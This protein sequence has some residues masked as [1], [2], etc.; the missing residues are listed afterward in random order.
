VDQRFNEPEQSNLESDSNLAT[1]WKCVGDDR[2]RSCLFKNLYY[3]KTEFGNSDFMMFV[4]PGQ[5][6]QGVTVF[7]ANKYEGPWMPRV[8]VFNS[9][10]D[11]SDHVATKA[12]V[13]ELGL[14]LMFNPLFHQNIGH[15]LFDGLYPAYM[16]LVKLGL[17]EKNF[18]PIPGIPAGCFD[19]SEPAPSGKLMPG[20]IVEAYLPHAR[21]NKSLRPSK[22]EILQVSESKSTSDENAD[23]D[24]CTFEEGLDSSAIELGAQ[25]VSPGD[26]GQAECCKACDQTFGCT[27]G[28][29]FADV[30]YLKGSCP[31]RTMC[32]HPAEERLMCRFHEE[33]RSKTEV[34]VRQIDG[35]EGVALVENV[36]IPIQWVLERVRPKCMSEGIYETFGKTGSMVRMYEM[37]RDI[38]TNPNV[39]FR[40][41]EIVIGSGGVGN[42]IADESGAIGGSTAPHNAMASFRNR[43]LEAYGLPVD[44]NVRD[45]QKPLDVIVVSNKRFDPADKESIEASLESIGRSGKGNIKTEFLDWGLVGAPEHRFRDHLRRVQKAD[46][47]VSSIGTALQYVPFMKDQRVYIALGSVWE[48]SKQLFPTF[49]EQQLAGGGTPYLRTLYA[50]PGEVLRQKGFGNLG[51]DG[52]RATVNGTLLLSLL[53]KAGDL[54]RQGFQIPVPTEENLSVEGRVLVELCREDPVSCMSMQADRNG[55]KYEC[56][57][58]LWP[59]C[60]VYEVGPWRNTCNLNRPLLRRLRKKHALFSYGAPEV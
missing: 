60:V 25:Q 54:V 22:V 17:E 11:I 8:N 23:A 42:L 5:D 4:Q 1:S 51:E 2:N 48:R 32:D 7:R 34:S 24:A 44:D 56:A 40:F 3:G 20:E 58:I 45:P 21:Y 10:K 18:R 13:E 15:A 12:V 9:S 35:E 50:D 6:T 31:P 52:F 26:E 39:L 55:A 49:M 29:I 16:A 43:M 59:E 37:D 36:T 27:R 30:C 47:Y 14:S 33:R 38:R 41:E 53:G 28:V 57:T 19:R 46:V